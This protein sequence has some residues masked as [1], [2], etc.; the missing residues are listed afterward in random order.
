[1]D[2]C[3]T[4]TEMKLRHF[5]ILALSSSSF[6]P[7]G[8][9]ELDS[10]T[11]LPMSNVGFKNCG[12]RTI[13]KKCFHFSWNLNSKHFI[14]MLDWSVINWK[15]RTWVHFNVFKDDSIFYNNLISLSFFLIYTLSQ[16]LQRLQTFSV[17]LCLETKRIRKFENK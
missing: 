6:F 13:V 9:L 8:F 7:R 10:V 3:C 12:V 1:M 4:H 5:L 15:Q 17:L 14:F 11:W 2:V 16:H